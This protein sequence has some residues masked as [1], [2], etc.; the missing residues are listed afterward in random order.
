LKDYAIHSYIHPCAIK[1]QLMG[2][3]LNLCRHDIYG[4]KPE[5]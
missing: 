4:L 2:H 5:G 3:L 1:F